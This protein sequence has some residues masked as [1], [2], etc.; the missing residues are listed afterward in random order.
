MFNEYD[1]LLH[2]NEALARLK[3]EHAKPFGTTGKEENPI[4]DWNVVLGAALFWFLPFVGIVA[5][6]AYALNAEFSRKRAG[7][8][9]ISVS[10]I[11]FVI[12]SV[13]L[14]VVFF[15]YRALFNEI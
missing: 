1:K 5:G 6:V 4:A 9:W 2:E 3:K 14:L 10:A 7:K 11:S 13:F 12:N 15:T 8:I